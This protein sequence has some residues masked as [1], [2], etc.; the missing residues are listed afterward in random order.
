MKKVLV[1]IVPA[2]LFMAGCAT[3]PPAQT[4]R[5]A[6]AGNH[7]AATLDALLIVARDTAIDKDSAELID[8]NS[9]ADRKATGFVEQETRRLVRQDEQL[10]R[11]IAV[12]RDI[13]R[14]VR[15]LKRYFTGLHALAISEEAAQTFQALKTTA[16]NLDAL[17]RQLQAQDSFQLPQEAVDRV[18]TV[19][20]YVIAQ[21]QRAA[22]RTALKR[23]APL[24][25]SALQVHRE[26]LAVIAKDLGH[27]IA[28]LQQ[29]ER[30]RML[31]IPFTAKKPLLESASKSTRWMRER[32][33][34]LL[35][36]AAVAELASAQ[37]A[38]EELQELL[39][40]L[41]EGESGLAAR[42]DGLLVELE[43]I[44]NVIRALQGRE[45]KDE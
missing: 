35:A 14:H 45:G 39:R 7:Y 25:R 42:I 44:R 17:T 4:A 41:V 22:L 8:Q 24:L 13:A 29:R 31:E 15:V 28:V 6:Q 5:F 27:D 36:D 1:V 33:R 30:Q 38:A 18:G 20:R 12:F 9:F 43:S 23:D 2:A 26:L 19:V 3:A 40:A 37:D 34:I 32:K 16:G 10:G 11:R 21:Q